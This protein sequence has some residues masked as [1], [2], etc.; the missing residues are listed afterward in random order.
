MASY[1]DKQDL[2]QISVYMHVNLQ[3]LMMIL[4]L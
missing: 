1:L 2:E 4:S 3:I